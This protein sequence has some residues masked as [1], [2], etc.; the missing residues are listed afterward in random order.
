MHFFSCN[1]I[2]FPPI[3]LPFPIPLHFPPV[4][5]SLFLFSSSTNVEQT[6]LRAMFNKVKQLVS[7]TSPQKWGS[8]WS[9]VFNYSE[10]KSEVQL[11]TCGTISWSTV[12][13]RSGAKGLN[14]AFNKSYPKVAYC[15]L[16]LSVF[17]ERLWISVHR[18]NRCSWQTKFQIVLL[19]T[20]ITVITNMNRKGLICSIQLV[21]WN[22]YVQYSTKCPVVLGI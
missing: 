3:P 2:S 13:N 21:N 11:S 17:L 9:T 8:V 4:T 15:F 1:T 16:F 7:C 20:I 22:F 18:K 10:A 5:L 19:F 12:F 6:V 14:T